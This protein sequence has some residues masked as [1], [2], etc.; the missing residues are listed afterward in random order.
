MDSVDAISISRVAS[1][2]I[3][4]IKKLII[5]I[6]FR[7][8]F[9]LIKTKGVDA[10]AARNE[11]EQIMLQDANTWLSGTSKE[12][13][14]AKTGATALHVASAKGYLKVIK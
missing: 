1:T 6:T 11:E 3:Q 7:Y 2:L 8:M 9:I 10:D 13:R 12:E 14:H 5:E 4:E